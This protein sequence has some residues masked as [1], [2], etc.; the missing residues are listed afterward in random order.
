M[1]IGG[2]WPVGVW[3]TGLPWLSSGDGGGLEVSKISPSWLSSG[4]EVPRAISC[5]R[6]CGGAEGGWVKLGSNMA[7]GGGLERSIN[8]L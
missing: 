2:G 3:N 6:G 4:T 1:G 5:G 8:I 7:T